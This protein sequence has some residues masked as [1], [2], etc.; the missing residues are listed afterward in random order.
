MLVLRLHLHKVMHCIVIFTA[1]K[2]S[3][4]RVCFYTCL[5]VILFTGGGQYLG[6]YPPGL[7][8]PPRRTRY[9][10]WD[11]VH[12][13]G[14]YPLGPGTPPP[15]GPGTPP[16]QVPP[17][18]CMLGDTGNKRAVRILLECILVQ[19]TLKIKSTLFGKL[20]EN[21]SML[22]G[23]KSVCIFRMYT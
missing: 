11:Q 13:P 12:P 2:R 14:R 21:W 17:K 16:L 9:T 20:V 22:R 18:Q 15:P 5:S 1:R 3:L 8:T 4:R 7:G 10:P 23:S 19:F 6:R